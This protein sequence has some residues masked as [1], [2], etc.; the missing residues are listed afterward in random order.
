MYYESGRVIYSPSDLCRFIESPFAAW[1][2]RLSTDFPDCG[3]KPDGE[4]PLQA[5]LATRGLAHEQ[6][7]LDE[8][9][10]AGKSIFAVSSQLSFT[11][12]LIATREAMSRGIDVI[13]Q[14]ALEKL[15][16]RG[17]ADFLVKVEG[18]SSLGHYH[19]TVWD[20][21]LSGAVKPSHLVQLCTYAEM[22]AECQGCLPES[23][24]IVLGSRKRD[25][26]PLRD[27]FSYYQAQK[28]Q[29]LSAETSFNAEVMPDPADS[30]SWGR[31][32]TYAEKILE[33]RDHLS[34]VANI[35]RA[36]VK[37]LQAAGINT[38]TGLAESE[39][40]RV[41]GINDIVFT[42]L[43]AQARIQQASQ[44]CEKP[45][46]EILIPE[47]GQHLGLS[48]LP[49]PS[50]LDVFFDIE[51]FPLEEGGLEYLWGATYF[52]ES[53]NRCFRDFWAHDANEEKA[54]FEAFMHWV[55]ER[56]QHDP[57]MHIYHYANYEIAACRRLMGRYGVCE[58]EVDQLLRNEVFVDLYKIVRHGLRLGERNY[59]IKSVEHLYRGKRETDV[60]TGGDSV[61]VYEQW[62]QQRDGDSWQ[63]SKILK[64]I[65]EYNIDDCDS[66]QELVEWL[67]EEQERH[68]ITYVG[69]TE[70][71]ESEVTEEVSERTQLR[72][73]LL[74]LAERQR[75]SECGEETDPSRVPQSVVTETLAWLLE[76]HRR[77]AKPVFWRLFDRL[78]LTHDELLDDIDCLAQCERTPRPPF[79]VSP[80][81]RKHAFEYR[82]D[83]NQEFKGAAKTFYLAGEEDD[84]GRPLKV[85]FEDTESD[86]E[87]GLIVISAMQEP[88]AVITL[89]PD[90]Y[91]NPNPIPQALDRVIAAYE[92]GEWRAC[93]I[94]DFLSRALP[95]INGH[96]SG[97][98]I[99]TGTDPKERLKQVIRGVSNL[100]ASYL[101]I[102]G[103][104]GAGKTYTGKHII[105]ELVKQGRTV[106]ICSNSHK[107]INNLLIGTA[108]YC[109]DQGIPVSCVCTKDTDSQL[110]EL[111]IQVL[112]NKD[113]EGTV[114]PGTVVGTTAWGFAREDLQGRFDYVFVDEAGQVSL[115]NLVAISGAAENI[116][117]MGDQM[118]LGQPIQGS[119][120]GLAGLSVLDYLLGEQAA[121][122]EQMGV[123][124]DTTYR[125]HPAV[126]DVVSHAFYGGRLEAH[127][128]NV[129]QVIDVPSSYHG[130]LD[131]E[132]GVIYLPVE[133]EGNTQASEEEVAEIVAR[134]EE[135]LGRNYCDKN[136]KTRELT[137]ADMLFMAPYNHQV[138]K[139][140]QALG[141]EAR[142][143]SVDK[144]QGQE[145]PIVFISMCASEAAE[146]PRGL[147]FLFDKHRLNVAISRA[148]ALAVIVGSPNLGLTK[149][150]SLSDLRRLNLWQLLSRANT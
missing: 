52:D 115:A 28:S 66:T 108:S 67:R 76:F 22:L 72:D 49:P 61:V 99:V 150:N 107:A 17:F 39:L 5:V 95:R 60:G 70:P 16:F 62:R 77:E 81:A 94:G 125:M 51:G 65:R 42:R 20:T 103:P 18:P 75:A 113:I 47:A 106:G 13:F 117:L 8:M 85:S 134:T 63:T 89:V 54:A 35:T 7:H 129:K 64:S 55:Y 120:P 147:A 14:A 1:M 131:C 86:L 90:E 31:W 136:G 148:Q 116:V 126:N 92:R 144:F 141:E 37:K 25:S 102:Q 32:G 127:P 71:R 3:I 138:N 132:A 137:L 21:K 56:W 41:P 19:Y 58:H 48:L 34:R 79:K 23:V 98:S 9:R 82:F 124:L 6:D 140:K 73:R 122:D 110:E 87:V 44:D 84:A 88:P 114:A 12:K 38:L 69:P 40:V 101:T 24:S 78:G 142:V 112:A 2:E 118:Q 36:Q 143:G 97:M 119:H 135:L 80:R 104:P 46:F 93:A 133:H 121:I 149:A 45:R 111:G 105:T 30:V 109:H 26:F 43:Q 53:G 4:D 128:D 68:G 145:A 139:L 100:Q 130:P 29:F 15:P 27:Y 146:S 91:V 11:E 83:A 123:F 33:E 57:Q 10:N 74:G 50:T 96:T 59:S